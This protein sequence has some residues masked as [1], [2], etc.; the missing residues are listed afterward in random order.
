MEKGAC[1]LCR[2]RHFL[3]VIIFFSTN[4]K[5]LISSIHNTYIHL[6]TYKK[7]VFG[8]QT[9]LVLAKQGT[10]THPTLWITRGPAQYRIHRPQKSLSDLPGGRC[11]S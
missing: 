4:T 7:G 11:T 10:G 1:T 8:Y 2:L 5:V 6:C 9:D 3:K